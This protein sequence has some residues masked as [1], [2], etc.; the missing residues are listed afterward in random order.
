MM[1]VVIL[2]EQDYLDLKV[3]VVSA[4]YSLEK[5]PASYPKSE[6]KQYLKEA[7]AILDRED[8]EN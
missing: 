3:S 6:L 5:L 2:K 1:K 4:L 7:C 8:D